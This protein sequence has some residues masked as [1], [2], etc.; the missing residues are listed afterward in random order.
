M[1]DTLIYRYAVKHARKQEIKR[2]EEKEL[3]EFIEAIKKENLRT[4]CK[5]K[6]ILNMLSIGVSL[7][8]IFYSENG[9][10]IFEYT[11]EDRDCKILQWYIISNISNNV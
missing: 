4:A 7:D 1:G 10:L 5:D 11:I 6:E 9:E 3:L 2:L 8:E